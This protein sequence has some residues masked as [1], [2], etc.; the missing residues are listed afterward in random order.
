MRQVTSKENMEQETSDQ[1]GY[2]K[3]IVWE[4]AHLL[5]KE[6]YKYTSSFPKM[7][8][9]VLLARLEDVQFQYRLIL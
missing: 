9:L 2:R 3:L 6:I 1:V 8:Y 5:V 4:K 7:N